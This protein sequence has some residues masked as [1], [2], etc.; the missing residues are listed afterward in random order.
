MEQS[1]KERVIRAPSLDRNVNTDIEELNKE[2]KNQDAQ[3]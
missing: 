1:F 2:D 3:V